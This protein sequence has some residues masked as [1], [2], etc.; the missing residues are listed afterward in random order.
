M[1]GD[2]RRKFAQLCENTQEGGRWGGNRKAIIM[3]DDFLLDVPRPTIVPKMEIEFLLNDYMDPPAQTQSA[4]FNN[5]ASGE[6]DS[7]QKNTIEYNDN[8]VKLEETKKESTPKPK[9]TRKSKAPFQLELKE[10][11]FAEGNFRWARE[12]AYK[13]FTL[14]MFNELILNKGVPVVLTDTL[15]AWDPTHGCDQMFSIEWLQKHHG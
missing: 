8:D 9:R 6:E 11:W 7:K 12:V 3:M 13:D 10:E 15:S 1:R 2:L 14:D 4:E 5:G